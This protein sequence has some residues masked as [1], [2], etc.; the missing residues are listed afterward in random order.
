MMYLLDT[1]T[2][3]WFLKGDKE[4]STKVVETI[5]KSNTVFV[6]IASI[7]ELS[8]KM[9]LGKFGFPNGI[10]GFIKLVLN[11]SFEILP[12]SLEDTI[13]VCSLDYIHKDPFDRIMI[14]QCLHND[15]ILITKDSFIKKY[16]VKTV[17]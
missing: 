16:P 11:N 5:E 14:A 10:E 4:L 13:K 9:S 6:S 7:W 8:I 3:I 1:H 17:W 2:L 15:L 12:I